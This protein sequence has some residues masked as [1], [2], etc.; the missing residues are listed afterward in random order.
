[1]T[2]EKYMGKQKGLVMNTRVADEQN[3]Q[4]LN[5]YFKFKLS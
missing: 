3:K 1:M 4:M 5:L 2:S